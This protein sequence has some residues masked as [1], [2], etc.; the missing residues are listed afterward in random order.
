MK[1]HLKMCAFQVPYE[2]LKRSVRDN[3]YVI[4]D[5]NTIVNTINSSAKNSEC[6]P[7]Q[8]ALELDKLISKLTRLKRKV[9][10]PVLRDGFT[11]SACAACSVLSGS[12]PR[13]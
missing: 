6:S 1:R 3:K 5:M 4:D 9:R 13:Q 11:L 8:R 7:E 10:R 2:S 12:R